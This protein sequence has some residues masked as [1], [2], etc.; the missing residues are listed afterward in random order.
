M[1]Q[2][3]I[4]F[5]ALLSLLRP[6]MRVFVHAGPAES[7]AFRA[8]L[9][10]DPECARGVEFF[11]I[12]IPG[13]NDFDYASLHN[14]ARAS[15]SFV[16]PA[17][18]KSFETGRFD[19]APVHYSELGSY[20]RSRPIDIAILHCPPRSAGSFSLGV[21]ADVAAAAARHAAQCAVITN[22]ALPFT[23][24]A[25]PLP[26]SQATWTIEG[27]GPLL[28]H[29]SEAGDE[30]SDRIAEHVAALVQDGD[31]VQIG[32]GRLP[33]AILRKLGHHRRL[34]M[35]TG[36]ITDEVADLVRLGVIDEAV[37]TPIKTGMAIGSEAVRDL[38]RQ[39][40]CCFCATDVTHDIRRI[41][42]IDSFVAINS[43]V[44]VDLFG[45]VNGEIIN[46]RQMSGIGGSSDF[47]RGARLSHNGRAIIALPASAR[48]KSRIVALTA[49][50][51]TQSRSD[52]DYVVTEYGVAHLRHRSIDARAEALISIADPA[53]R[54][55]LAQAWR[56]RRERL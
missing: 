42:A 39:I 52:A 51:V 43:A 50:P 53:F 13:I 40:L 2:K 47:T 7:L 23:H 56:E 38:A 48:G 11:G 25:D 6:G 19:F 41:A 17:A 1:A 8:A 18:R 5:P 29:P 12:F 31:T 35:H 16:P 34:K 49:G 24:M 36:M 3:P 37:K 21:N 30:P 33:A 20:V 46:G 15:S 45:Q 28:S 54:D 14:E 22:P 4:T 44:E 10:G 27:E 32:I 55:Q 9:R 26:M